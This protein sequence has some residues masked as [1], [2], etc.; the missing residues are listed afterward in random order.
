MVRVLCVTV[1]DRTVAL[2]QIVQV[3][4][5]KEGVRSSSRHFRSEDSRTSLKIFPI[6]ACVAIKKGKEITWPYDPNAGQGDSF[7]IH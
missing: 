5:R 6:L 4:Y 3:F 7:P 1:S 2:C